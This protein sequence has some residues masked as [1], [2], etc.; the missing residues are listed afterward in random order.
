MHGGFGGFDRKLFTVDKILE[1]GV[2]FGYVSPDGEDAYPGE[3]K[4]QIT[5]TFEQTENGEISLGWAYHAA[6]TEGQTSACP[7]NLTNHT[8]WNLEGHDHT[9]RGHLD[10]T[11]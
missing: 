10:H 7:L 11:L 5:Y 2:T 9:E 1:N 8:Y 3:I 4:V 6:M